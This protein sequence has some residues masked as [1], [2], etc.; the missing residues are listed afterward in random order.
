MQQ[1]FDLTGQRYGRL[2]VIKRAQNQGRRTMW[3]CRCD[4][5]QIAIIKRENLRSGNTKS[6]GCWRT[7]WG[8]THSL[9][10]GHAKKG[11]VSPEFHAWVHM[12]QRCHNPKSRN[13]RHWGGRGIAVCDEWRHDFTA[14]FAY[15]GPKPHPSYVLDRIDNSGSYEPG[16]VR[17]ATRSVSNL[18]RRPFRRGTVIT[19][20]A[21]V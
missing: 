15:I 3:Q 2:V 20:H 9:R 13:Y 16:N 11:R 18:N 7:E 5:G 12:V 19:A 8:Y 1:L 10:H 4:C 6:C 17:W 14:F 21:T